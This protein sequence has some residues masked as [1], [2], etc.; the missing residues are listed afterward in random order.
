MTK[1]SIDLQDL[2]RRIYIKAKAEPSWRFCIAVLD[3]S[4]IDHPDRPETTEG[5]HADHNTDDIGPDQRG[6]E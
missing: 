5:H 6:E 2:R 4:E 1:A 3:A